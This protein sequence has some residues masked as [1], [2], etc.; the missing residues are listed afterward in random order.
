MTNFLTK[1]TFQKKLQKIYWNRFVKYGATP[2][3]SFWLSKIRQDKRFK[4]ILDQI[5][6]VS[7]AAN[8]SIADIGCGYGALAAYLSND[9]RFRDVDYTGYDISPELVSASQQK[10][11]D[12]QFQFQVG[13]C[14][15]LPTKFV[16]MSGTYNL[17]VTQYLPVWEEYVFDSIKTCWNKTAK[18]M[19]FNLQVAKTAHIARDN[20]Y[21]ADCDSVIELC[22][23]LFGPT[24][25]IFDPSLPNDATFT[26]RKLH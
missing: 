11:A 16:V 18:A 22:N 25:V 13:T 24:E 9:T 3:G 1:V 15:D 4:L 8:L 17:A 14:P 6:L 5:M 10:L 21:Y 19:I 20:I 23:T 7:P 2:T 12:S 26:V